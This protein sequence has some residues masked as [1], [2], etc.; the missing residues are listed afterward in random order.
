MAAEK[1][2]R[3]IGFAPTLAVGEKIAAGMQSVYGV[4]TSCLDSAIVLGVKYPIISA[5]CTEYQ[6]RLL[7]AFLLGAKQMID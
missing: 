4:E 3:R 7:F 6:S 1:K 5:H 2:I